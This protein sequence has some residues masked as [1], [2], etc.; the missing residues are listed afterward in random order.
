ME[1]RLPALDAK[2]NRLLT[3]N[4]DTAD[5]AS[6]ITVLS[7]LFEAED[8]G[9]APALASSWSL[10][11]GVDCKRLAVYEEYLS[12]FESVESSLLQ[13]SDVVDSFERTCE[14][15]SKELQNR[16]KSTLQILEKARELQ[17][18][19][20]LIRRKR[21][22]VETV[23]HSFKLEESLIPVVTNGS[24]PV[25]AMFFSILKD[26]SDIKDRA[27][28]LSEDPSSLVMY[29]GLEEA[30]RE[31]DSKGDPSN[32]FYKPLSLRK[33][34]GVAFCDDVIGDASELLEAAYERCFVWMHQQCRGSGVASGASALVAIDPEAVS[35]QLVT[36]RRAL[37]V[38]L[39]RPIYFETCLKE[40]A[41]VR[42]HVISH[43]FHEALS[44]GT[45][46]ANTESDAPVPIDL[47]S[48]DVVRYIGDML[49]WVHQTSIA[50]TEFARSIL[51]HAIVDRGMRDD[52]VGD[53][54][55][56]EAAD[57]RTE[58]AEEIGAA[59]ERYLDIVFEGIA[60]PF[61]IRVQQSLASK[62][63]AVALY[64]VV[65]LLDFFGHVLT[66]IMSLEGVAAI[67]RTSS[68]ETESEE[69]P[70]FVKTCRALRAEA[71]SSFLATWE[72]QVLRL[73][74]LPHSEVFSFDLSAPP[75]LHDLLRNLTEVM[76]IHKQSLCTRP[77][78]AATEEFNS[79]L[80]VIDSMLNF[81]R[82]MVVG[83]N[84]N[85][86]AVC[87]INCFSLVQSTLSRQEFTNQRVEMLAYLIDEQMKLLVSNEVESQLSNLGFMEPLLTLRAA[88]HSAQLN[89]SAAISS[90]S[91]TATLKVF[92][93]S[94]DTVSA[95][96]LPA[97]NK[98][99]P[100][101]LRSEARQRI[102]LAI[103][104]AYEELHN[105]IAVLGISSHPPEKI[106]KLLE[107]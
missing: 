42:S 65:Q 81:C 71:F 92:Y 20:E 7:D 6:A 47:H 52:A 40:I 12:Y 11:S 18:E 23:L 69:R 74:S 25:N 102:A 95:L 44:R 46:Q 5:V 62:H 96:T 32:D 79:I 39:K 64:R 90:L 24:Q 45:A 3:E 76:E 22:V 72:E 1:E 41:R 28:S 68:K 30:F 35:E 106:R 93:S 100:R 82:Q 98:I 91:L 70:K 88:E 87:L 27:K 77:A 85:D 55:P 86:G 53:S 13:I 36:F 107:F 78:A 19:R 60:L 4:Y 61:A 54:V 58:T 17:F 43:L 99:V 66:P 75:F 48:Y 26:I 104:D 51:P 38:L 34:P 84:Q 63:P 15:A 94:L 83:L 49:A 33:L 29:T 67:A 103:G 16:T 37:E 73:K 59:A 57:V 2:V 89:A 80:D 21:H 56:C 10:R 101:S 8:L 31:H 50:E 105:R 9:G 97:V 14:A